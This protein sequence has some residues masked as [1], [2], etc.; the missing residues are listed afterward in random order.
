MK[1]AC[2]IQHSRPEPSTLAGDAREKREPGALQKS[3]QIWLCTYKYGIMF[4]VDFEWDLSK[5]IDNVHKHGIS[6]VEAM[7]T[8][9][10]PHGFLLT[11]AKHSE[12][13]PRFFWVGKSESGKVLTTRFT[14]RGDVIRIFGSASWRR[15]GRLYHERTKTDRP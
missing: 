3:G 11:D 2:Q 6:F 8:F 4:P 13:E 10:D 5:E 15:F 9:S 14:R 7:E 1:V 12:V